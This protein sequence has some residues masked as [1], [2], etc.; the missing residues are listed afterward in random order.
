MNQAESLCNGEAC[1]GRVLLF[2]ALAIRYDN[3]RR[4]YIRSRENNANSANY[5][6]CGGTL[7][8][9]GIY[10]LAIIVCIKKFDS[11]RFIHSRKKWFI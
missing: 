9:R 11:N 3:N 6:E 7:I 5:M 2:I 1:S 4:A 8:E 10:A